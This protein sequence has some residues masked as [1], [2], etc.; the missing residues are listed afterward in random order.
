M[1]HVRGEGFLAA[2]LAAV[3]GFPI[4]AVGVTGDV[5]GPRDE[6]LPLRFVAEGGP[7]SGVVAVD[8]AAPAFGE[9]VR[10]DGAL[11]IEPG[12]QPGAEGVLD[13]DVA[14]GV[15]VGLGD[16]NLEVALFPVEV[17]EVDAFRL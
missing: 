16:A 6:G 13:L 15:V 14:G 4:G 2:G 8:Q 11:A 7:G 9:V 5:V 1:A 3:V 17:L 10:D 12:A